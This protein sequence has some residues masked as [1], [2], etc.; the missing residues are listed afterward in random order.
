[1]LSI[2]N[3]LCQLWFVKAQ[4][5]QK[6]R[7]FLVFKEFCLSQRLPLSLPIVFRVKSKAAK[8]KKR[9]RKDGSHN[10]PKKWKIF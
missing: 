3:L 1:M 6:F 7:F 2:P 9:R 4:V 10:G 5:Y 8:L